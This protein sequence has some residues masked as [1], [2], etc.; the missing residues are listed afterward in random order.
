MKVDF[1]KL[2][3]HLSLAKH[4]EWVSCCLA[5]AQMLAAQL[6]QDFPAQGVGRAA[7]TPH[8]H[9]APIVPQLFLPLIN[10]LERSYPEPGWVQEPTIKILSAAFLRSQVSYSVVCQAQTVLR[11]LAP[12]P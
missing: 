4:P 10:F 6:Y 8:Q 3:L 7:P 12:P 11:K 1:R 9:S 5:A 2:L